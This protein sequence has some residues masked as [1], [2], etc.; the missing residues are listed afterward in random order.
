MVLFS[1]NSILPDRDGKLRYFDR[2]Y[3]KAL[4]GEERNS[5]QS[6]AGKRNI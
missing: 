6:Y 5:S 3:R 4:V 1:K 2:I